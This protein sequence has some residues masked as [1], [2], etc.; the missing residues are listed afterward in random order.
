MVARGV[1]GEERGG[2]PLNDRESKLF[3]A[4]TQSWP[5]GRVDSLKDAME[6]QVRLCR[7]AASCMFFLVVG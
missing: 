3:V 2:L 7:G 4:E 6:W 1:F 5:S